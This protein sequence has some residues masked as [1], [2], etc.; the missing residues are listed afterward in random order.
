MELR[1]ER[2]FI[3]VGEEEHFGRAP[4]RQSVLSLL[5]DYLHCALPRIRLVT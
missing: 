4:E 5:R 3:R 1:H 2:Y